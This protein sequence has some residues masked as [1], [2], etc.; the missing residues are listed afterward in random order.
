V[1]I[2]EVDRIAQGWV[3]VEET[4]G[5]LMV[6]IAKLKNAI[7]DPSAIGLLFGVVIGQLSLQT[8]SRVTPN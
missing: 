4:V 2:Q 7:A 6:F 3:F 8:E 1:K 5:C